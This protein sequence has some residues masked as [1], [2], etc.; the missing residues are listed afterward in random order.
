MDTGQGIRVTQ[1][2]NNVT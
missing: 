2:L 1:L